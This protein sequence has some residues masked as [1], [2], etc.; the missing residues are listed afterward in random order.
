MVDKYQESV[1]ML[2]KTRLTM[3]EISED[4]GLSE[5]WLAKL[6]A[7]QIVDPGYRKVEALYDY[8]KADQR[9]EA[10][11]RRAKNNAQTS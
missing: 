2:K 10:K 11:R 7:M 3:A 5:P 9:H 4:L 1:D 8:L 6:K